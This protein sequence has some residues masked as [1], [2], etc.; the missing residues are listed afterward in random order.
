MRKIRF[1]WRS[2]KP[3]FHDIP[4]WGRHIL[5]GTAGAY[6]IACTSLWTLQQDMVFQ[7]PGAPSSPVPSASRLMS[8]GD[9]RY[10]ITAPGASISSI[11]PLC[12]M[13]PSGKR[14][15]IA[16]FGGNAERASAFGAYARSRL[17]GCSIYA[18]NY[19]G[20]EGAPGRPGE[21]SIHKAADAMMEAMRADGVDLSLSLIMG[22]S[23]GS[24][25]ATRQASLVPCSLAALITP[26]DSLQAVA[27][28]IYPW[29]PTMLLMRDKFDA[30]PW[31]AKARCPA[32]IA[33]SEHD[34]IIP[35]LHAAALAKSW[36]DYGT[37]VS[38]DS[39]ATHETILERDGAW[40]LIRRTWVQTRNSALAEP[41]I[42]STGPVR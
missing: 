16:Y 36:S 24:G 28:G 2:P 1:L 15:A 31:A 4:P 33:F 35:G 12:P 38:V 14:G 40:D 25:E 18:L 34:T 42:A 8:S 21:E 20:Y 10:W 19:P 17:P 11:A 29:A 13:G 37:V 41:A 7:P 6:L 3:L 27:S 9:L 32:A 22:R 30:K 26:Y 23:L 39:V 5:W